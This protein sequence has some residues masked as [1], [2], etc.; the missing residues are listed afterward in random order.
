[1]TLFSRRD[2]KQ[3]KKTWQHIWLR[4]FLLVTA[5]S[6]FL[7][8]CG[9]LKQRTLGANQPLEGNVIITCSEACASR[10]QCGQS[11]DRG[12]FVFAASDTPRVEAHDTLLPPETEAVIIE[13][14]RETRVALVATN[15]EFPVFFYHVILADQTKTGWVAGWCVAAP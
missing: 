2:D 3:P 13:P 4:S 6:L 8:A 9:A 7:S 10:G 15:E 12:P 11:T 5:V 14:A 1:M